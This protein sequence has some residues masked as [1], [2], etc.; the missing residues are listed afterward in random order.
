VD[1]RDPPDVEPPSRKESLE[2]AYQR[3]RAAF[4]H[5]GFE[6]NCQED[7]RLGRDC[8]DLMRAFSVHLWVEKGPGGSPLLLR[9]PGSVDLAIDWRTRAG[10]H[11]LSHDLGNDGYAAVRH[12]LAAYPHPDPSIGA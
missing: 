8:F 3:I 1:V 11:E 2:N 10:W 4:E 9:V 5:A 12:V 7:G 6:I